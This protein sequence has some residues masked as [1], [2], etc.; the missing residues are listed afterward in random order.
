M[1]ARPIIPIFA[2]F[3][4][5]SGVD[6]TSS[7][8]GMRKLKINYGPM[9][10]PSPLVYEGNNFFQWLILTSNLKS[11]NLTGWLQTRIVARFNQE[12]RAFQQ[13]PGRIITK[14]T[15]NNKSDL[16]A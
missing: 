11:A 4:P 8:C 1:T 16:I 2:V 6:I 5:C 15:T 13:L 14:N 10:L 3:V 7:S 12:S 9:L